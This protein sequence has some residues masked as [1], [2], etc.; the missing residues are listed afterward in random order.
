MNRWIWA[1]YSVSRKCIIISFL[2]LHKNQNYRKKGG[3]SD[4]LLQNVGVSIEIMLLINWLPIY[5]I[6]IWL[7]IKSLETQ[8]KNKKTI[9]VR[10]I[11]IES[12]RT[13]T[14]HTWVYMCTCRNSHPNLKHH[15]KIFSYFTKANIRIVSLFISMKQKLLKV[16]EC[17]SCEE[18]VIRFWIIQS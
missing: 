1:S 7:S 5:S 3:R 18:I 16:G 6:N 11:S 4:E 2:I 17:M 9:N 12:R 14:T 13:K 10:D 15:F 8:N